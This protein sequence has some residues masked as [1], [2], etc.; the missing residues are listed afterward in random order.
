VHA[1]IDM[2]VTQLLDVRGLRCPMVFVRARLALA[3]LPAGT[4]LVVLATDPEAP[5]DLAALAADAGMG[6][7]H[8]REDGVWRLTFEPSPAQPASSESRPPTLRGSTP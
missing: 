3:R 7:T 4:S 8:T 5:I 6:F 1:I 2:P